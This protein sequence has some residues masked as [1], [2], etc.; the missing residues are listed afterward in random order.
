MSL[1]I[2]KKVAHKIKK[3]LSNIKTRKTFNKASHQNECNETNEEIIME[4]LYNERLETA[5]GYLLAN[6]PTCQPQTLT[7]NFDDGVCVSVHSGCQTATAQ[8]S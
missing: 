3:V 1:K 6:S 7:F 4:N 5:L 8:T 2:V